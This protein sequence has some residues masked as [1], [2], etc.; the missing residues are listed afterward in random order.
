M[1]A[2]EF[3]TEAES[4]QPPSIT[5]GDE[6]RVGKFKNRKAEV[7]GFTKDKN[8]QPVLKTTKGDQQLFKP[9]IAKL[10]AEE[11]LTELFAPG[12][13][14]KWDYNSDTEAEAT[15][16]IGDIQYRFYAFRN[17]GSKNI[18]EVEFR[19]V[20]GGDPENRYGLTGTGNSVQ[21]MSTVTDI[22]RAFLAKYQNK[23]AVLVFSAEESSR[24]ALYARMAKKLLP[25]WKFGL[26]RG[27]FALTAPKATT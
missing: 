7:Q 21:V 19:I 5:V 4:Y 16:V 12:K 1:R 6:V 9:R 15:F 25:D 20:E 24:Q 8:N 2:Q 18:W 22:L 11:E 23:I 3:I 10:M 26:L 14:W 17:P 27:E 13:P